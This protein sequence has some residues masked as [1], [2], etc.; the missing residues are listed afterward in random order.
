MPTAK[1]LM[2][3]SAEIL[4]DANRNMWTDTVLF[5]MLV[6][7]FQELDLEYVNHSLPAIL[8]ISPAIP[9][10]AGVKILAPLTDF[11]APLTVEER[12]PGEDDT[13]WV[14]L[15]QVTYEPDTSRPGTTLNSWAYREQEIKF[16]GATVNREVRLHYYKN[17]DEPTS[18]DSNVGVLNSQLF[19]Q[20]KT[21]ANAAR[22]IGQRPTLA[23]R[24]DVS[25]AEFLGKAMNREVKSIQNM[26]KRR[27]GYGTTRKRLG[28]GW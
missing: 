21:A 26:P 10:P 18:P 13:R 4:N 17:F 2:Q 11:A 22:F 8:D 20:F 6:L 9:I 15:T 5:P 12:A 28:L 7:S 1:T 19:L 27:R 14:A 25:A 16:A 24:L 3:K 23:D